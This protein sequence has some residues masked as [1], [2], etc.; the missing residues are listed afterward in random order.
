MV[1]YSGAVIE[2]VGENVDH[3]FAGVG[4]FVFE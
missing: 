4:M 2:A 3:V 1:E